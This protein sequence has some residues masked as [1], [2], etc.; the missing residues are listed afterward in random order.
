MIPP[1]FP[2]QST[3]SLHILL[4]F[5]NKYAS[6]FLVL[7]SLSVQGISQRPMTLPTP[8]TGSWSSCSNRVYRT[9]IY[10]VSI[11]QPKLAVFMCLI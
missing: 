3:H 6:V 4:I 2:P 7:I 9:N 5:K 10:V 1:G 11:C 8:I